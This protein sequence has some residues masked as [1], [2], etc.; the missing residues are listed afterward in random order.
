MLKGEKINL[1]LINENDLELL[2]MWRNQHSQDF[3]TKDQITPQ[4]Q[5]AWYQKYSESATDKMFILQLKDGTPIGTIALYNINIA[6]RSAELGRTLLMAQ[7][8]GSGYM[9]D[10]VKVLVTHAF[11]VMRIWNIR[12]SVYL[13]NAAAISL[14]HKCGFESTERPIMLMEARNIDQDWRKS[15]HMSD[16]QEDD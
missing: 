16:F 1:R 12:L 10:A 9:E 5:R 14:Y 2:R 6:D 11:E 7:F 8:R 4:Q 3:F 15:F 13:D